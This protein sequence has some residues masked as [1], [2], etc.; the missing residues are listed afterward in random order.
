M[1]NASDRKEIRKA[2]KASKQTELI[3]IEFLKAAMST[4]QGRLWFWNLLG[5]C[6]CRQ[7]SFT[8]EALT[9]AFREGERNIGLRIEAA[10]MVNC[11]DLYVLMAQEANEREIVRDRSTDESESDRPDDD[12]NAAE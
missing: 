12:S 6:H 5:N 10:I 9:S 4:R 8:G 2:E 3:E 11:P 7:T 1:Q